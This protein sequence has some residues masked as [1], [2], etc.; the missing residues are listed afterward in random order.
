M[1]QLAAMMIGS[2]VA[3]LPHL[4]FGDHLS[5]M[6]NFMLGSVLGGAAY[7][8]TIYKLKKLRGDF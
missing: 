7:V 2:G 3:Y 1:I 4:I 6:A 8:A 5:V